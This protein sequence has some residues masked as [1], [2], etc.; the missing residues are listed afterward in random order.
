MKKILILLLVFYSLG[1]NLLYAQVNLS[2]G[3]VGK[4]YFNGNAN[5]ESGNAN[6]GIVHGAT[7]VADRFGVPNHAYSFNGSNAYIIAPTTNFPV[8]SAPISYS[9]WV[10]PNH[11][12]YDKRILE[13]GGYNPGENFNF[14][15][16]NDVFRIDYW[17]GQY[18]NFATTTQ[19]QWQHIVVMNNGTKHKFFLNGV[20][21]DSGYKALNIGTA[22]QLYI[23]RCVDTGYNYCGLLDDIRIYNRELN[24]QEVWALYNET[25]IEPA[26][27]M[28]PDTAFHIGHLVEV[29]VINTSNLSSSSNIISY[30]FDLGY[31]STKIKY[32]NYDLAGTIAIGG[33]VNV[34]STT[35]G[36]LHISYMSTA[37]LVG[38]G[39]ILKLRFT[40]LAMG[41][42][43][44]VVTNFLYNTLNVINISDGSVNI[45]GQ[46]GDVDINDYVQ[47]YDAALC[48]Q[49]SS[50]MDP[51][52]LTD[53]LPWDSWRILLGN[54]DTLNQIT[55]FDASLILQ[56]SCGLISSFPADGAKTS[57][58]PIADI[59]ITQN[60]NE[61]VFRSTG[62]LY[63]LNIFSN[64]GTNVILN[65][66][67]FV[68]P[69]IL[70]AS[71]ISANTY[72]IALCTTTAPA[73]STAI[74]R[75]PFSC[76]GNEVLTFTL[77]VNTMQ[78]IVTV[79]VYCTTGIHENNSSGEQ[80]S[81]FPNPVSDEIRIVKNSAKNEDIK[82]FLKTMD[83]KLVLSKTLT[84][85]EQN[86][87]ALPAL[88][89]GL[90]LVLLES[91]NHIFTK[92]ICVQH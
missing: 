62:E 69:G 52:P 72:N 44:L 15:I 90:Y 83:G 20:L 48:L 46:Y 92:M 25:N 73:D 80:I 3:L 57:E 6:D 34:N 70:T 31:D 85:S 7:L 89:D 47:A 86:S 39:S 29:P 5:D 79:P 17:G 78:E 12:G 13:Y 27:V 32:L 37:P 75:I 49:Y 77:V 38:S 18:Y 19:G 58:N 55:A 54:V 28:I 63:G 81:I 74:V 67:V 33:V 91:D 24:A 16:S 84:L 42:S 66:P 14:Y 26:S 82:V 23:G 45:S 76:T 40:T 51:L 60:N 56:Y 11:N 61:L 43:P 36:L 10:N 68:L 87:I 59:Y 2:S 88:E 21:Q 35:S 71:N 1:M 64:N 30:Q 41:T 50:G 22:A 65:Q 53:P 8:G 9:L 4:Y